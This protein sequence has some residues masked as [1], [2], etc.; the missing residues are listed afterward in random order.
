MVLKFFFFF[1]HFICILN[2]A[3][4]FTVTIPFVDNIPSMV[5]CV[6]GLHALGTTKRYGLAGYSTWAMGVLEL[7][8][9]SVT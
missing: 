4:L 7:R 1:L 8:N 2:R 5:L 3:Q 9:S 6:Y